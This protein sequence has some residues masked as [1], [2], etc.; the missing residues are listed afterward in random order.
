MIDEC[1]ADDLLGLSR[2]CYR[3]ASWESCIDR[4]EQVNADGL[5]PT[6]PRPEFDDPINI[7]YTAAP[8]EIRR[9]PR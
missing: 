5:P 9:A 6:R 1:D 4:G 8:P 7:Q 3:S 2:S